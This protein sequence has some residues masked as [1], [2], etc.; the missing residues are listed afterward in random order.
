MDND[1]NMVADDAADALDLAAENYAK[2]IANKGDGSSTSTAEAIYRARRALQTSAR[3]Y[4]AFSLIALSAELDQE[5][6]VDRTTR[7]SEH[8][9]G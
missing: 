8:G 7:V 2:V 3:Q 4:V 6:E 5:D 1:E 9:E